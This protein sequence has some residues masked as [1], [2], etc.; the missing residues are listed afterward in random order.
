MPLGNVFLFVAGALL[1]AAVFGYVILIRTEAD[2]LTALENLEDNIAKVGVK[3]DKEME[4]KV[5]DTEKRIKDFE[6]LLA[7]RR[8]S[9]NFFDNFGSLIHPQVWFS[10]IELDVTQ[11][12]ASVSGE[13]PN[14][15]TL[16]QQLIFLENQDD[17]V[18]SIELS[19]IAIGDKG[20]A[21]FGLN[22]NFKP[23]IF[24]STSVAAFIKE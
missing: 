8:K 16:E 23:E 3:E 24:N 15:R 7:G 4:A 18:E 9:A 17:L 1:L 20:G 12:R 11:M 22:F 21:E 14:F 19:N 13:S 10:E 2:A 5:F 6:V